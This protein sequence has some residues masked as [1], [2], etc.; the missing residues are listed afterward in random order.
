VFTRKRESEATPL[1]AGE[2]PLRGATRVAE[3]AEYYGVDMAAPPEST[4]S[5]VIQR[6]L[7][8][9]QLHVGARLVI[10]PVALVLREVNSEGEI[11]LVGMDPLGGE[12]SD[13][14]RG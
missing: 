4:L 11:E 14:A 10:G 2:F 1:L 5:D 8:P 3:I 13:E 6:L 12:G 9:D 7:P